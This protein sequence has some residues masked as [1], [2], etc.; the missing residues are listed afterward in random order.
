MDDEDVTSYQAIVNQDKRSFHSKL[1]ELE[2][3]PDKEQ[4][5]D[6][7]LLSDISGFLI[8]DNA[9]EVMQTFSLGHFCELPDYMTRG[10]DGSNYD[11]YG[12]S[13][14][15]DGDD[16]DDGADYY[17]DWYGRRRREADYGDYGTEFGV[18]S[19]NDEK[20]PCSLR[21]VDDFLIKLCDCIIRD[22]FIMMVT[23]S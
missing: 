20:G 16:G 11:P 7:E 17:G 23:K 13:Y 5:L 18:Y 12:N 8:G 1:N 4:K 10:N 6:M 3:K 19:G 22:I 14:G 2:L 15:G 21:M 9:Q